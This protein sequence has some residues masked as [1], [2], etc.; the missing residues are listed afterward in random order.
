MLLVAV[1]GFLTQSV[2]HTYISNTNTKDTGY[3]SLTHC[4]GSFSLTECLTHTVSIPHTHTCISVFPTASF[5]FWHWWESQG[6]RLCLILS[7]YS[8]S[9]PANVYGIIES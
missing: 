9:L 5:S 2:S 3:M 6:A 4:I 7:V 1:S 8:I